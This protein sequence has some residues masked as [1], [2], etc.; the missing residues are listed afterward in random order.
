M[1]RAAST[2]NPTATS[3]AA[4]TTGLPE[5]ISDTWPA[6]HALNGL[7]RSR[8]GQLLIRLLE[9]LESSRLGK[10]ALRH[11]AAWPAVAIVCI[12]VA[13]YHF[14]LASLFDFL[15]LQT[16]LAYVPLL[17]VFCVAMAAIT[18][19]RYR[20]AGPPP[21]DRQID[22]IFGVPLILI[23]LLLITIAPVVAS[24]YYWTDRAD[25]ISMALFA[26]GATI[27]VYGTAWFWR[28]KAAFGFLLLTWP[29][30]YLHVMPGIMQLFTYWTNITM[31]RVISHFPLGA[32][33]GTNPGDVIITQ[34]GGAPLVVSIGT[35]CS[36]ADTVLGFGLIGAA[37]L[38][39]LQGGRVRKTLWW[40]CGLALTFALN[41][42]RLSSII[43]LAHAGQTDLALGAY[44]ALIGLILFTCTVM[45]MAFVLPWFGLRLKNPV[46]APAESDEEEA[47]R[48][49]SPSRD[50]RRVRRRV[51]TGLVVALTAFVALADHGLQPFAAFD[52]GAGSPVVRSFTPSL[53]VPATWQMWPVATY[54]W[55]TQYFGLNASW[56]RYSI[57]SF[58][59]ESFVDVVMTDDRSSLDTYN[60]LN[61]F[62]FHNYDIRTYQRIDLGRG[63][64]GLL[65]NYR[66]PLNGQQWATVSWAWPV[67][68]R[69]TTYYERVVITAS[70]DQAATADA[71]SFLPSGGLEDILIDLL[72]GVSGGHNDPAAQTPFQSTDTL[73]QGEAQ[74][75]VDEAMYWRTNHI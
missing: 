15:R 36:G 37:I 38:V 59:T 73:L 8:P 16:P 26:A 10:Y 43:A 68:F 18:A 71:P 72:N 32:T 19:R 7:S 44:H 46:P 14:T 53:S 48:G 65:V 21:R 52:D 57:D 20:D 33:L 45:A 39:L 40:I 41:I 66:E 30:L 64:Y 6:P 28:L 63:V 49:P 13:A 62:L 69:G 9:D 4:V 70:P 24:A 29:A 23:A 58:G 74:S 1:T 50:Y 60:L 22:V 47:P 25:V 11:R 61:C 35:A 27:L 12:T 3:A 75:M 55:A 2:T 54:G 67:S 51:I 34:R 5:N 17:P 56:K 31:A 42:A